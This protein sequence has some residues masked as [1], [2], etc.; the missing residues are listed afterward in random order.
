MA[1][2]NEISYEIFTDAD[3]T[4]GKR[5]AYQKVDSI[6]S[7]FGDIR[8]NAGAFADR[9]KA[10]QLL[11]IRPDWTTEELRAATP[12]APGADTDGDVY[13]VVPCFLRM[14]VTNGQSRDGATNA[15]SDL[16][17]LFGELPSNGSTDDLGF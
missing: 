9:V 17:A 2:K 6:P 4:L 13:H 16:D 11:P 1:T 15:S 12:I 3:C 5:I 10:G 7:S 8:R 14:K